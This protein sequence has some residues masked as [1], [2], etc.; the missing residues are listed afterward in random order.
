MTTRYAAFE[1]RL[2]LYQHVRGAYAPLVIYGTQLGPLNLA[3][4]AQ[5]GSQLYELPTGF[6]ENRDG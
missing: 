5:I 2:H 4:A 3:S 6:G 1:S